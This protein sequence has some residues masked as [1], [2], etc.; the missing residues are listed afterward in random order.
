MTPPTVRVPSNLSTDPPAMISAESVPTLPIPPPIPMTLAGLNNQTV[1]PTIG[2]VNASSL[3][4][5]T[6][7]EQSVSN[8][9]PSVL[10]SRLGHDYLIVPPSLPTPL[11]PLH[12]SPLA[13]HHCLL[14][15]LPRAVAPRCITWHDLN[16][17]LS[18]NDF[19]TD[20]DFNINFICFNMRGFKSN[21]NDLYYLCNS[22]PSIILLSEHWLYNHESSKLNSVHPDYLVYST[23]TPMKESW[24]YML[25]R[26][27]R[28]HGGV[29][30]LWH[31]SYEF[32]STL[33][34]PK[35][36]RIIGIRVNTGLW[37]AVV[38]SLYLPTRSGCTTDFI[39]CLDI[40]DS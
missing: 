38:F 19:S 17:N 40:L 36:E 37:S 1:A 18:E 6:H 21:F 28:G 27:I 33:K 9:P 34:H 30:I 3:A 16:P 20:I 8:A 11:D 25:P 26:N 29:A 2:P 39:K 12:L 32:V 14:W 4:F 15:P 31:K 13:T 22:S 23:S 24:S 10:P 7:D 35:T 5:S